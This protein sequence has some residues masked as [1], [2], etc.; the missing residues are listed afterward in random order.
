MGLSS[1]CA[2]YPSR[3]ESI[4]QS[5]LEA[6]DHRNGSLPYTFDTLSISLPLVQLDMSIPSSSKVQRHLCCWPSAVLMDDIRSDGT[7]RLLLKCWWHI[8]ILFWY[9]TDL[10]LSSVTQCRWEFRHWSK[11]Y[12]TFLGLSS[13]TFCSHCTSTK[14]RGNPTID[15]ASSCSEFNNSKYYIWHLCVRQPHVWSVQYQLW[16][17][18]DLVHPLH[19]PLPAWYDKYQG[20]TPVRLVSNVECTGIDYYYLWWLLSPNSY[21]KSRL[22][23]FD[24]REGCEMNSGI[25]WW[26]VAL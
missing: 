8:Y 1:I 19:N 18:S 6:G 2:H 23:V 24:Q 10:T 16:V 9:I 12:K 5:P 14:S 17:S 11:L 7:N 21:D 20:H 3:D 25:Q 13:S 15:S 26:K 22:S 4:Y